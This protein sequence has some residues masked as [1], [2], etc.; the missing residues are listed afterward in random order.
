MEPAHEEEDSMKRGI[1]EMSAAAGSLA[2]ALFAWLLL[3]PP[4]GNDVS[5]PLKSWQKAGSY[6]SERA[7]EYER[8]IHLAGAHNM[9]PNPGEA[10]RTDLNGITITESSMCVSDT[11]ARLR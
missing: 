4:G 8:R 9:V 5:Q 3:V 1:S 11:D 2:A 6:V 7:C 10:A